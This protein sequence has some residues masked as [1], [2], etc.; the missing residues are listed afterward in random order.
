MTIPSSPRRA[1]P[2]AGT[3]SQTAFGFGFKV[4]DG[5]DLRVVELDVPTGVESEAVLGAD[6]SVAINPDQESTPGGTV[7]YLVAPAAS[8]KITVVGNLSYEQPTDLPDGGNYRA[9]QVENGLDRLVMLVQQLKEI[10]DRC[11]QAP[12]SAEDAAGLI[13]SINALAGNLATL[14]TIV[15]NISE[16]IALASISADVSTLAPVVAEIQALSVIVD[17]IVAVAAIDGDVTTVA[18]I[19]SNVITVSS[20]AASVSVVASIAAQVSVVAS[21]IA[22]VVSAATN[23]AAIQAAPAAAAAAA[24]SEANVIATVANMPGRNRIIGGCG[25]IAQRPS[26]ALQSSTFQYGQVDRF[27]HNCSAATVSGTIFRRALGGTSNGYAVSQVMTT[28]GATTGLIMQRVE[29]HNVRDLSGKTV[30]VSGKVFHDLAPNVSFVVAIYRCNVQDNHSAMTLVAQESFSAPADT[31]TRFEAAFALGPTDA[32]NGIDVRVSFGGVSNLVAKTFSL[33][34]L[35]L[36]EGAVATPFEWRPVGY[37]RLLCMRYWQQSY[38]DGTAAGTVTTAGCYSRYVEGN[39]QYATM[40]FPLAVPMRVSPTVA[41]YN[42]NTGAAASLASDAAAVAAFAT[43]LGPGVIRLVVS[44]TTVNVN[45]GL[46]G[47][48]TASAEL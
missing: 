32:A 25:R 30:T 8:K 15:A 22:S 12:V 7:N 43:S 14:Q 11:A 42:P 13:E 36:E 5:I 34:D 17:E 20:I 40:L 35:Q 45:V 16:L 26:Y 46:S 6:Y 21:N 1:G 33:A 39:C 37:E 27:V 29:S 3:G 44:G 10:T 28:T 9:Q 23:M 18:G 41:V 48:F 4:F 19:A 47:H 2:Y 38:V 24:Q 31:L